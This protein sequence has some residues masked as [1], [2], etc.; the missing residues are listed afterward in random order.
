M[1]ENFTAKRGFPAPRE[2]GNGYCV[3]SYGIE[4][5]YNHPLSATIQEHVSRGWGCDR[6][7][8]KYSLSTTNY[9]VI[10][11]CDLTISGRFES[12]YRVSLGEFNSFHGIQYNR[13]VRLR[14]I[15]SSVKND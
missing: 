3:Y 8:K 10:Y 9:N 6:F 11:S 13:D 4:N 12:I 14:E 5:T 2:K 1:A 15:L 7:E